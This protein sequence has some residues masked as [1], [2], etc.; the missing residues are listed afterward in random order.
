MHDFALRRL[1]HLPIDQRIESAV[2]M[3]QPWC[4]EALYLQ[5]SPPDVPNTTGWRPLHF[6]ARAN[7][8]ECVMML[9][10]MVE[11]VDV[12]ATTN[13]GATPLCIALICGSQASADLIRAA[14][15][16]E[17]PGRTAAHGGAAEQAGRR[18][19]GA[20]LGRFSRPTRRR[21]A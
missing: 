2:H 17:T 15:G 12:N 5:G 16:K 6:A 8:T 18:R 4:V 11:H 13:D 14:G 7:D 1:R 20:F 21:S 19:R 9:L 10:H 3:R